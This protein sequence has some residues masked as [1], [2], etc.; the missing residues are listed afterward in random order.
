MEIEPD[1]AIALL[2]PS[3]CDA[4][5]AMVNRNRDHLSR[6]LPWLDRMH[7][8]EDALAFID[9]TRRQWVALDGFT[10]GIQYKGRLG[11][12]A[13]FNTVNRQH[14][15]LA[16]GYWLDQDLQGK[17]IMTKVCTYLVRYAF[18]VMG[19][20]RIE[21][22]TEVDNVKSRAIPER[23]GFIHEGVARQSNLVNGRYVDHAVYS[24][25][26]DEWKKKQTPLPEIKNGRGIRL[27]DTRSDDV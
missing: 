20:N 18:E 7:T 4:Y 14:Q 19:M 11:G 16:I 3:D 9:R 2:E 13:G 25:L 12:I 8:R 1:L 5:L 15:H 23:L 21:L 26:A 6:W 17:G 24:L 27:E 22:R 10:A